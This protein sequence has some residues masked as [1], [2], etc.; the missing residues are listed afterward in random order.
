[1]HELAPA[2]TPPAPIV[3]PKS[4]KSPNV[5]ISIFSMTFVEPMGE[6]ADAP[7]TIPRVAEQAGAP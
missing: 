2:G 1:M 4:T 3:S 6:P 5:A 7:E